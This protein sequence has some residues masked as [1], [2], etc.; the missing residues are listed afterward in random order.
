MRIRECTGRRFAPYAAAVASILG[1][2][3]LQGCAPD[4]TTTA[5]IAPQKPIR[6]A[7]QDRVADAVSIVAIAN[8][9]FE[10]ASL[11][12]EGHRFSSGPACSEALYSGSADVGTMGDTT[13]VIAIARKAPIRI[14]A[15][16][17]GGEHRHRIIVGKSSTVKTVVDLKGKRVAVKKGDINLRWAS[18]FP[19]GQRLVR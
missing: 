3:V 11:Q 5:E 13:A 18:G 2:I 1:L 12:V 7:Y 6:M 16:H 4:R 17:G 10:K 15:S 19:G 8:G 9:L 14:V